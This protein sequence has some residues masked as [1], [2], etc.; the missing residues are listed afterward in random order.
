MTALEERNRE[1]ADKIKGLMFTFEDLKSWKPL[2]IQVILRT[3]DKAKLP[4]ALKGA[5]D[6]LKD[7]F[8]GNMSER[9]SKLL[10]EDIAAMGPVRLARCRRSAEAI[11]SRSPRILRPRAK[12]SLPRNTEEDELVY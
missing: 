6:A 3:A 2:R 12:S 9:A 10:K 11:W 5:S 7:L 1:S 4:I 8:F